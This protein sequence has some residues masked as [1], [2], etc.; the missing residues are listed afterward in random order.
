MSTFVLGLVAASLTTIAYVPQVIKTYKSKSSKDLSL[1]MLLTFCVG[2]TLWLIY[3]VLEK[4]TPIIVANSVTLL[5]AFT[6]LFFKFRFK[7]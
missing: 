3:G 1:K 7:N 5:L 4:D 6:L 2:V